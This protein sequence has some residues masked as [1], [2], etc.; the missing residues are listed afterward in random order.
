L[1]SWDW[2]AKS[3]G[4]LNYQS[5]WLFLLTDNDGLGDP[6]LFIPTVEDGQNLSFLYNST[7]QGKI[8]EE[9][10]LVEGNTDVIEKPNTLNCFAEGLLNTYIMALH[11]VIRAEEA[12]YFITGENEWARTKPSARGRTNDAYQTMRVSRLFAFSLNL[13]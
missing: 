5:Q 10:D 9:G 8:D 11:Q 4:M 13:N 6:N 2:Q 12:R 3:I 1:I 7:I